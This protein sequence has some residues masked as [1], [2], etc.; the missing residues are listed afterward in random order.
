MKPET[1]FRAYSV[2]PFLLNLSDCA[3]FPIQ[4]QSIRGDADFMVCLRGFFVWLE[5]KAD[6]GVQD[7]L[8]AF[9]ASQVKQ[10]GGIAL[11]ARPYNW[12]AVKAFLELLNGGVYDKTILQGIEQAPIPAS[13]PKVKRKPH[14]DPAS[15]PDQ[16]YCPEPAKGPRLDEGEL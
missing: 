15:I 7:A 4:Q 10:A 1:K 9:K 3:F 12:K 11:I 14:E 6:D 13:R 2:R 8:Q 5:L 16:A